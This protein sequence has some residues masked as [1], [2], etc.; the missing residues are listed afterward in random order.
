MRIG[1]IGA[2]KMAE[3]MISAL[4]RR[5]AVAPDHIMAID[6]DP[7]RLSQM[8][9]QF[10]IRT[11]ADPNE[12]LRFATV[13][14]LAVKPQQLPDLLKS[15]APTMTADRLVISIAAGKPLA[16]YETAWPA[17]RMVRVMP[18]VACLVG[19][20]MSVFALGR[21]ATA[22]DRETVEFL[23][24]CFGKFCALPESHFDVVTA[25]SGSGPAFLAYLAERLAAAAEENGL[26]A[27]SARLLTA[28]T[29]L[30]T[31]RLLLDGVYPS[32]RALMDAVTSTRGTTAA[33]RQIL[34][35]SDVGEVLRQTIRAATLRSQELS[36][37]PS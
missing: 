20:A 35:S 19:E 12:A 17:A 14:I 1:F 9:R 23:L 27:D 5:Q 6:I 21:N 29:L 7:E 36:R 4:L 33:G 32:P 26:P 11:A 13:L 18:N 15:L 25:L 3:A 37:P 34:E 10:S 2:G 8:G 22:A 16:F 31:A 28:Q 24:G 30:G